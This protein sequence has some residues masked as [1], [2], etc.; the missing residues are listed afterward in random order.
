MWNNVS[1]LKAIKKRIY[2]DDRIEDL[3]DMLGCKGIHK[4]HDRI[5]ASLP[6]GDNKRSVQVTNNES[7]TSHIRSRQVNGDIYAIVSYIKFNC[8]TKA[9]IENNLTQAK[10][11]IVDNFGY[12]DLLDKN[13]HQTTEHNAWLKSLKKL[14]KRRTILEDLTPNKPIPEETKN[15]YLMLP[16]K[17]WVEEGISAQTQIEWEVGFD[18]ESKRIITLVRN[19]SGELIGVKGRAMDD[20]DERKYMYVEK[21]NKSIELFGLHKTLPYILEKKEILVF[22]GYKSVMKAWQM[23]YRN[24]AS[25]EGDDLSPAQVALIKSFGLDIKVVLCYDKD[26]LEEE[27]K[28]Q[29]SK[30]TNRKTFYT[31]DE[32]NLLKGK[33]SPVDKGLKIWE[34]LY[35]EKVL[36]TA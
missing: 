13:K 24:C 7:L 20:N 2:N 36:Y 10:M 33:D 29:A 1:D 8:S 35:E 17:P 27:I 9:E 30:F 28:Q 4:E 22:E 21:M 5:V 3:L 32:R 18:W 34:R 11:W 15:S 6:T 14:R 25:M 23:G 31:L 16:Y 26:K 19:M 12:H